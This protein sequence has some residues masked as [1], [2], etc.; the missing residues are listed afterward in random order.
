MKKT[1]LAGASAIA[2]VACISMA[3]AQ[4]KGEQPGSGAPGM[5][6]GGGAGGSGGAATT[7]DHS[8]PGNAPRKDEPRGK[9]S[10]A[11]Q[12]PQAKGQGPDNK[13]QENKAAQDKGGNTKEKAAQKDEPATKGN[14][15]RKADD[16]SRKGTEPDR[17]AADTDRNKAAPDKNERSAVGG[18]PKADRGGNTKGG[19]SVSLSG[20]KRTQVISG[21]AKHRT[22]ARENVNISINIGTAVPRTVK[23]YAVPEEIVVIVPEYRRYRYFIVDDRVCIVDPVT[24]EII[25]VIILT[26]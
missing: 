5:S 20:E 8:E 2:L 21:F 24:F 6:Q 25:D 14:A 9:S 15:N 23:L 18:D 26:A 16:T 7:P 11:P 22:E 17:K 4:Q 19:V 12:A 13:G 1:H 10:S 3:A